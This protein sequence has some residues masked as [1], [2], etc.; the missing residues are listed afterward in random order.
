VPT[1]GEGY[2]AYVAELGKRV[3]AI[4]EKEPDRLDVW[5]A[6]VREPYNPG[7][8]F[9]TWLAKYGDKVTPLLLAQANDRLYRE[10]S[11]V[12]DALAQIVRYESLPSTIHK[13]RPADVA[14]VEET[15]R[16]ALND[17][18]PTVRSNAVDALAVFGTRE[19]LATIERIALT[20]PE[21]TTD[22]GVTGTDIRFFVREE[23]Q[24][25]ADRLKRRLDARLP[26]DR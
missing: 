17:P 12:F 5:P 26:G 4:A 16:S 24:R 13:L 20:D 3:Q 23:A 1:N 7:S 8:T 2:G 21:V 10:T 15:I 11:A 18:K 9:T 6:L 22:A 14:K 25:A 19:D